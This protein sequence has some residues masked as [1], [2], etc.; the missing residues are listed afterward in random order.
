MEFVNIPI[1]I[2]LGIAVGLLTGGMLA[3]LFRKYHMRDTVK[4]FLLLSVAFLLVTAE[5]A[6]PVSVTFSALLSIMFMGVALK[7]YR[8]AVAGRL[9]TKLNKLW[10]GAE[11]MLFVLV[12][13]TVD[14]AYVKKAGI[15]AV[16][17]IFGGL[18]FRMAGV[19]ICLLRTTLTGKE[20]LFCMIA[21]LPKATVQAAIGS[22]PLAMG[23]EGGEIVLMVAVLAILITAPLG[24]FGVDM[25]YRRF[26]TK[27]K[28][29]G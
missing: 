3:W 12:G 21:Y 19:G 15:A 13:A 11:V 5:E 27:E 7:K 25:T 16:L 26:L 1:S 20:R 28:A 9:S 14:L 8:A 23:I 29:E 6:I 10:V 4:V 17:L 22:V 2:A 24:A 18:L